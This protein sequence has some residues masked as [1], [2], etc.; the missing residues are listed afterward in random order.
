MIRIAFVSAALFLGAIAGC[1]GDPVVGDAD[2]GPLP[3][4]GVGES[5]SASE[6]CTSTLCVAVAA[7]HSVC[8]SACVRDTDCPG[9]GWACVQPDHFDATICGCDST[10]AEICGDGIDNDCNA[11]VDDCRMCGGVPVGQDDHAN[12]GACGHA[13][14]GDQ[15][16]HAGACRCTDASAMECGGACI[17]VSVSSANCGACGHACLVGQSCVSGACTCPT[18]QTECGGTCV[19]TRTDAQHC[20]SCDNACNEEQVCSSGTCICPTTGYV[21]CGTHCVDRSTSTTDCGACG[22]ACRSDQSC[23]A[24]ACVCAAGQMDCGG[25]CI[26]TTNDPMNCGACGN[27]CAPGETCSASACHCASGLHCGGACIASND[28]ANCGSCGH[29]C[30]SAEICSLG[31]CRCPSSTQAYCA[32]GDQCVTLSSDP[33]NCGTCDHICDPATTCVSS[34]CVCPTTG[35][36]F[37]AGAGCVSETTDPMHCGSCANACAPNQ[38]CSSSRCACPAALPNLCPT[39]GC[40]AEATDPNNCGSCGHACRTG[41]ICSGYACNCPG[42][43]QRWCAAQGTCIDVGSD[44]NNCGACGYVCPATATCSLGMCRCNV[45]GQTVCGSSCV[46][47]T[48]DTAH[49][50]SCTRACTGSQICTGSACTCLAA[51]PGTQNRITAAVNTSDTVRGAWNGT[52][53]AM[54]VWA[55]A[56]T[57]PSQVYRVR[58]GADGV[59]LEAETII[60]TPAS[61]ATAPDIIWNGSEFGVVW[62]ETSGTTRSIR[63][64]RF[65]SD[66][67]AVAPTTLMPAPSDNSASQL[68]LG[69]TT[70]LGYVLVDIMQFY[71]VRFVTL[72]PTGG[73]Y[74]LPNTFAMASGF[75][76]VDFL[77]IATA[78]TGEIGVLWFGNSTPGSFQIVNSD[79]SVT[80]P[81]IRVGA[82]STARAGGLAHDGTTWIAS[83]IESSAT[84]RLVVVGRG[85]ALAARTTV[86]STT[87]TS[88][89]E[90]YLE[91]RLAIRSGEAD[92]AWRTGSNQIVGQRTL[93]P[94]SATA[95]VSLLEPTPTTYMPSTSVAT[96]LQN[97]VNVALP[98]GLLLGWSDTRWGS[99]E[100]YEQ[101]ITLPACGM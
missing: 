26:A 63:V 67:T 69:W 42:G 33:N 46:D 43:T 70:A 34:N 5:C 31:T 14:R 64:A 21:L 71:S 53:V 39:I 76:T 99:T 101:V 60:S 61:T 96:L 49:C 32:S 29:V 87:F 54:I 19:S 47:M 73:T 66:G 4:R 77:T 13:C 88:G 95:A 8:T 90:P 56:R 74:G 75:V 78:P 38:I 94:A 1:S 81:L 80:Q 36:T 62:R 11:L 79:G 7:G 23:R 51:T 44:P 85:A 58:V 28:A 86:A 55:D 12:C 45:A 27:V 40:V 20:G 17:D 9:A 24:G 84:G 15:E 68:R 22:H 37:C 57:T 48:T 100:V 59:P 83:W 91:A 18:G 89:T 92:V 25:A 41:E 3:R 10:G 6:D 82:T 50:G 52:G 35:Q 65:A 98:S 16:C 72:G 97:L 2:A 30:S 93:L